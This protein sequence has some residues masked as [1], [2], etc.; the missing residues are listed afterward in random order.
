M[1]GAHLILRGVGAPPHYFSILFLV[2]A[3]VG[4][5]IQASTYRRTAVPVESA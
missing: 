5:V 1:Q 4:I 2:L 3:I